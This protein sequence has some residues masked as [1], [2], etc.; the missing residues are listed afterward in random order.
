MIPFRPVKFGDTLDNHVVALGGSAREYDILGVCPNYL[1]D[2]LKQR[3][4]SI[5]ETMQRTR[6]TRR[7][8]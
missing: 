4:I 8:K 6:W 1:G 5:R 3:A 7:V 2:V